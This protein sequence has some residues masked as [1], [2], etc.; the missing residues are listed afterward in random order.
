M[1][2]LFLL[3]AGIEQSVTQGTCTP[4]PKHHFPLTWH[5]TGLLPLLTKGL[6]CAAKLEDW[7]LSA[8]LIGIFQFA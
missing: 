2:V 5:N 4:T 7:C 3:L 8:G 1:F 6:V